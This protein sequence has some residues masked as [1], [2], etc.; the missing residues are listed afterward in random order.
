[1]W[2]ARKIAAQLLKELQL[3]LEANVGADPP[4]LADVLNRTLA[5]Q[6]LPKH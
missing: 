2:P 4:L 6:P 1:M 5:A 3:L